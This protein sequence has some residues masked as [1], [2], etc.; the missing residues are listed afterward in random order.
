MR[1]PTPDS[2]FFRLFVL[3]FFILSLSFPASRE[4]FISLGWV[5]APA[6]S[7][8]SPFSWNAFLVRMVAVALTAWIAARWVSD[9]IKRMA[10]ASEEL[11][12]NLHAAPM[13]ETA[14]PSEVRQASKI[15]NQMQNRLKQQMEERNLFLAAV[16]H[17]LRTPLTRLRLRAEK[18][19]RQELRSDVQNDINEMAKIIDT[20]LDYLRADEQPEAACLLD[21]G[22]LVH[23]LAENANE[24]GHVVTV[25]GD[26]R[27][28]K[29]QQIAIR[30]CLNNLIDN[31]LRYGGKAAIEITETDRTVLI[32]IHDEG[33]GIPEDK[34]E[35]VFVPFFRLDDSRNQ[36]TGG[37]GLGLAIAKDMAKKQGGDISLKN[38][39]EG[40]LVATLILPKR[41]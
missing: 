18:I 39:T 40:G 17:D 29:L 38:A 21:V 13:N 5:P 12:K 19:E 1:L 7:S 14:G 26:A 15:F 31:A 20:T 24:G 41:R 28:I 8:Y 4:I 22:A 25:S 23:S 2:L 27:P 37:I 30:R 6:A 33:P 9:S 3:L 36:H 11:G 10:K 16:S 35:A 34:L 32:A